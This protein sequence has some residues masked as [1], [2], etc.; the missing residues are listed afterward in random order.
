MKTLVWVG[1]LRGTSGFAV[2]T[3]EYVRALL[4]WKFLPKEKL[5]LAPLSV[6][7]SDDPFWEFVSL[8]DPPG[9]SFELVN[10]LPTTDPE[11]DGYFSVTEFDTVPAR[12]VPLLDRAELVL[13]QSQFCREAFAGVVRDPTKIHVVPYILP[14]HFQPT[15]PATRFFPGDV[16]AFGSVFE[17]IPRKQPALLL[18]AFSRAFEAEDPVGLV[19][20]SDGVSRE[21]FE[22]VRAALPGN[23]NIRL[24]ADPLPDLASFYR[25]LDA[26]ACSSAG[27]GWGQPLTEA[28][29]CG[30]PTIAPRHGGHLDFMTDQNAYLVAV[31]DW[32]PVPGHP[33]LRWRVPRLEAL[34]EAFRQ[35]HARWERD[36][37]DPRAEHASEMR[38]RY[39]ARAVAP[40]LYAALRPHLV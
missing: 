28:M 26:Y 1:R 9:P 40:L 8:E 12:W 16:C 19:I 36:A 10:H 4:A 29:A 15:G 37:P 5:V 13:T 35:V 2:A 34:V 33:D 39:S 20:R 3:R 11:A 25:G 17:W 32:S 38:D 22:T 18:E 31:H 14:R 7:E 24:L 21:H 27:E 30:L 6:L 23:R